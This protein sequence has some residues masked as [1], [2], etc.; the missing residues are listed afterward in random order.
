MTELTVTV[1]LSRDSLAE[2]D[3]QLDVFEHQLARSR[4]RTATPKC[5]HDRHWALA[6]AL[7]CW[8]CR[9]WMG[10]WWGTIKEFPA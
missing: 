2:L 10:A 8:Q 4:E 6:K 3:A 7:G 9:Q 1:D 5:T